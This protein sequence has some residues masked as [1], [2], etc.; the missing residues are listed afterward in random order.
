[1]TGNNGRHII[2]PMPEAD[3]LDVLVLGAGP[4]G[5]VAALR[6]AH[7]RARTALVPRDGW[8]GMAATAGQVPVRP[9]P[10][11][12]PLLRETRQGR[13]YGIAGGEPT[14]DYP[15]L[16]SRVREVTA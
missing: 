6:A 2:N 4:A 9:L 3:P 7:L 13:R 14:L 16:L 5:V 1:M 8:A 12:A 11:A 10:H 15:D